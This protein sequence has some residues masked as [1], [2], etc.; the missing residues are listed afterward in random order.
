M[1]TIV[2]LG[3]FLHHFLHHIRCQQDKIDLV[4]FVRL[5]Y[6][7]NQHMDQHH[8]EHENLPFQHDRHDQ[9]MQVMQ[10]PFLLPKPVQIMAFRVGR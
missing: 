6:S 9:Q 2:K 3:A 10:S 5:H 7:D 1:Q 8:A 4:E